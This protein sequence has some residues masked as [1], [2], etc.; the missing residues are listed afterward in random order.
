MTD[1]SGCGLAELTVLQVVDGL[2]AGRGGE[3]VVAAEVLDEVDRR[4]GLG[5][6]Y[7][8][9]MVCDLLT[10]WVI[11]VTLLAT[12]GLPSD[13]VFGYTTPAAH[14]ECRLSRVGELVVA[15]EA[16]AIAPVPA[17][18]INGGWWRG[19]AQPPLDPFRV[20]TALRHLIDDPGLPDS[21]VLQIAGEPVSLTG[22]ELTGDLGALA[23]GQRTTIRERARITSTGAPVP[24]APAG[25]PRKSADRVPWE[26]ARSFAQTDGTGRPGMP[27][28]LIIDAVPRHVSIT[29]LWTQIQGQVFHEGYVPPWPPPGSRH[30]TL[31][32]AEIA[33]QRQQIAESHA[34]RALPIADMR[35]DSGQNEIPLAI[36]LRPGSDPQVVQA[37]L[38]RMDALAIEIGAQFPAA[39]GPAAFLGRSPPARGHYRQPR[40]VRSRRP[41]RPARPA[42]PRGMTLLIVSRSAWGLVPWQRASDR[43]VRAV[44]DGRKPVKRNRRSLR[45]QAGV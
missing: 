44:A 43:D 41:S 30:S 12:N 34:A 40:P 17:G 18:L 15:A 32:A 13:R 37:Q 27:A 36:R 20:I 8:Y 7:A 29:E 19:A 25:P 10:P 39:R 22:S 45:P 42:D 14:T 38:R 6:S 9:P 31:P 4:I 23:E 3:L 33:E 24:P 11:P 21:R 5:P 28:H 35:D 26:P 16:S 1:R 2:S